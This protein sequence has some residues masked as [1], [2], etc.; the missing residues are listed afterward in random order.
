MR[1]LRNLAVGLAL[2]AFA[3]TAGCSQ[4]DDKPDVA[5]LSD[6]AETTDG[7]DAS[8]TPEPED[9]EAAFKKYQKCMSDEG[10]DVSD[11][12]KIEEG[13]GS[14]GGGGMVTSTDAAG[15]GGEMDEDFMA[16]DEKCRK[17][18]PN[19]GEMPEISAEDLDRMVEEA[20]CMREHGIEV[21]DPTADSPGLGIGPGYTDEEIE[22]AMEACMTEG[23]PGGVV[24]GPND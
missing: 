23:G 12:I 10:V 6:G 20:Q 9:L 8:G 3:L 1:T 2:G 7:A 21:E 19:G 22:A 5:S 16:A 4:P 14:G 18:L 24:V 11:Q 17:H 15:D 13:D